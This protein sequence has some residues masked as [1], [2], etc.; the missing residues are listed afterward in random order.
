MEWAFVCVC[1][2]TVVAAGL[3]GWRKTG[4]FVWRENGSLPRE[5]HRSA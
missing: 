4:L 1:D 5:T 3:V 2:V